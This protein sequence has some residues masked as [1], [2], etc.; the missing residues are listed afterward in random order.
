MSQMIALKPTALQGCYELQPKIVGDERGRFVKTFH[1]RWFED[2]GL[3]TDFSEQYYSVSTKGVLRGLHFQVPPAEHAKL[4]YCPAGQVLDAAVDLRKGSSTYGQFVCIELDAE[5]GNMLYL[6]AGFAHGFYTQSERA[7]MVYNVTSVHSPEHDAGIRWDS[8]GIPWPDDDVVVSTRDQ[9][10][11]SLSD[12]D[13][14]FLL[15]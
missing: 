15:P 12:F 4:V 1:E 11:P 13:S 6:D 2:N 5:R 7:M 9:G 8:V 14:P 3:R 10:L